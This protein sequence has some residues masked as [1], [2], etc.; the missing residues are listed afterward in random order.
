MISQDFDSS[1]DL[2]GSRRLSVYH[3]SKIVLS[4]RPLSFYKSLGVELL[5]HRIHLVDSILIPLCVG[6]HQG[7]NK[8]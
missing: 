4:I 5:V 1:L 6:V 7:S 2:V 3:K 8:R